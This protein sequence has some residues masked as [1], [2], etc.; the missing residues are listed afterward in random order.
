MGGALPLGY[1]CAAAGRASERGE[2]VAPALQGLTGRGQ[3]LC[4]TIFI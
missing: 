4:C 2:L 1:G 3:G